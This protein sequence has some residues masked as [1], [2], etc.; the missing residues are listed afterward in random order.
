MIP[1]E[2]CGGRAV[3]V[4]H[5]ERRGMGGSKTKDTIENLVAVCRD[6]HRQAEYSPRFNKQLKER[7]MDLLEIKEVMGLNPYFWY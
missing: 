2:S 3:D 6:C 7:H 5:L 1:C 4:H